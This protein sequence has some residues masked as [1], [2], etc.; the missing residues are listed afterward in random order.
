M[1]GARA[2]VGNSS[3]G[4]IEA[5]YFELPFVCVGLRQEGRDAAANA[6][7]CDGVPESIADAL[8]GI[9]TETFRHALQADNRPFGDGNASQRIY[10]VLRSVPV[11]PE[12]FRKR[13]MY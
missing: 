3:A 1:S 11:G 12:L 9:D 13:M 4:I 10:D 2:L 6:I 8:A 7:F 5:P